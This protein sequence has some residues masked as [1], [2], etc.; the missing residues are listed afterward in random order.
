MAEVNFEET[1]EI[2]E[3]PASDETSSEAP[4]RDWVA[5][6]LEESLDDSQPIEAEPVAK[7]EETPSVPETPPVAA[8]PE[9]TPEIP[10][11][12]ETV[13]PVVETPEVPEVAAP[14]V[15][16]VPQVSETERQAQILEWRNKVAEAYQ[17]SEEDAGNLLTDPNKVLPQ[18][19]ARLYTDIYQEVSK[20]IFDTL[21]K[22]LP[23]FVRQQITAT[24][25]VEKNET[26]FYGTWPE[27]K[28]HSKL[29]NDASAL[30]QQLNA[31][32]PFEKFVKDVGTQVWLAVGL[33][34]AE[35]LN[36][37]ADKPASTPAAAPLVTG[38]LNPAPGSPASPAP[39]PSSN[40]FTELA[41]DIIREGI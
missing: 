16:E 22:S 40:I 36:K 26:T 37:L 8:E 28:E 38:G 24:A 17:V 18:L 30:Y 9:V 4:A 6:I 23:A 3:D 13:E 34:H 7:A 19:A 31:N 33:P 10:P 14:E 35:L 27:L 39:T 15:T 25:S 11:V 20:N 5:G 41:E 1:S 32:A 2:S 29:V 21:A 12:A